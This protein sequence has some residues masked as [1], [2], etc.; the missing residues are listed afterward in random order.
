MNGKNSYSKDQV[1]ALLKYSL[2]ENFN[3]LIEENSSDLRKI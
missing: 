3:A 2:E 1:T